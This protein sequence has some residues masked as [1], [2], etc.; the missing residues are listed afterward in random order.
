MGFRTLKSLE[1]LLPL[2]DFPFLNCVIGTF[3]IASGFFCSLSLVTF[4]II[5]QA[6]YKLE[7]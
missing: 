2:L 7:I 6:K 1:S 4:D 3:S 5:D